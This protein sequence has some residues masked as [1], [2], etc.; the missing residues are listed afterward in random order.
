M[1]KAG[2]T[3]S[4]KNRRAWELFRITPT[5]TRL[6][7]NEVLVT[8]GH[9][10]I[11]RRSYQHLKR[12]HK[13]G[14]TEYLTINKLDQVLKERLSPSSEKDLKNISRM[15]HESM[16]QQILAAAAGRAYDTARKMGLSELVAQ[17][18]YDEIE[19]IEITGVQV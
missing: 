3:R 7:I 9:D 19:K 10:K 12:L 13:H 15:V 8:E 16:S 4:E 1:S 11:A 2:D 5:M 6:Q 14:F 17:T 18:F